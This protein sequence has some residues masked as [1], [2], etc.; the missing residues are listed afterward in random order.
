VAVFGELLDRSL[1]DSIKAEK[2][3]ADN[4]YCIRHQRLFNR[5]QVLLQLL[6]DVVV[7]RF[8]RYHC[9]FLAEDPI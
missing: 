9:I 7:N 6:L 8:K 2:D 4:S 5:Q 3:G 1:D